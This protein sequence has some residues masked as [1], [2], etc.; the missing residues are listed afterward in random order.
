MDEIEKNIQKSVTEQVSESI[1][2]IKNTFID[3]LK[4]ENLKLQ[5]KVKKLED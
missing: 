2:G 5:N 1:M 3:A 4:G